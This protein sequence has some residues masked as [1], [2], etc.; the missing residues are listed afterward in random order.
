VTEANS[1]LSTA[2]RMESL[3]HSGNRQ[4]VR[5]EVAWPDD[6]VRGIPNP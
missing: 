2:G 6:K 1:G 4:R 5:S 3:G